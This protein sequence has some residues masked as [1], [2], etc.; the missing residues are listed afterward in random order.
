[1]DLTLANNKA[2][3]ETV[4]C[5]IKT[6]YGLLAYNGSKWKPPKTIVLY[7]KDCRKVMFPGL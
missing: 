7:V 3:V 4:L 6:S 5:I 2:G 1:M